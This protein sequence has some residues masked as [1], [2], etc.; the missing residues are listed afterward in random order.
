MKFVEQSETMIWGEW[1]TGDLFRSG[2]AVLV[3]PVNT[4]GPMGGGIAVPFL[5]RFPEASARYQE[6]A[7]R[8]EL[9]PG[10]VLLEAS[11]RLLNTHKNPPAWIAFLATK[12]HWQRPSRIEWIEEGLSN[13]VQ[14]LNAKGSIASCA[15][16]AL[17]CGHGGLGWEEVRPLEERTAHVLHLMGV[18]VLLYTPADVPLG[19]GER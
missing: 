17:G 14:V 1:R 15:I 9:R 5:R 4:R 10:G 18:R 16:P 19:G 11:H 12:D 2:A 7:R 8:G 6:S 13:L 3:C